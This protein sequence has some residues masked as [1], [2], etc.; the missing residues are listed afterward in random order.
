MWILNL[1]ESGIL[2]YASIN[3]IAFVALT[4]LAYFVLPNKKYKWV[5]LLIS[6]YV[7]YLFA[8]YKYVAFIM[9]TTVSTYAIARWID[10]ISQQSKETLQINKKNG[11]GKPK[12]VLKQK[13]NAIND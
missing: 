8:G 5:V 3:F 13:L 10:R 12:R 9:F 6:S 7:F 2:S 1:L 11:A 4:V